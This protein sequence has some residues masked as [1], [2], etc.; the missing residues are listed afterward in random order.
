[1]CSNNSLRNLKQLILAVDDNETA[2]PEAF[3]PNRTHEFIRM[4][5]NQCRSNPTVLQQMRTWD[6]LRWFIKR[7]RRYGTFRGRMVITTK[8]HNFHFFLFRYYLVPLADTISAETVDRKSSVGGFVFVQGGRHSEN[9]H[10][11][12]NTGFANCAI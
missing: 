5:Y 6:S 7:F 2:V 11:I 3:I 10:L 1:M 8:Y 4:W 9:L 12:H